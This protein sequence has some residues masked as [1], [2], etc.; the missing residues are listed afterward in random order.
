V[1]GTPAA[2]GISAAGSDF[3]LPWEAER[4]EAFE[5]AR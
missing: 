2:L 3:S 1:L 4:S 5:W